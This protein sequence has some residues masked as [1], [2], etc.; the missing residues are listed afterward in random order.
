M[1]Q[2][3]AEAEARLAA[4]QH[5]LQAPETV[6]DAR[7]MEAAWA[8]VQQAQGEVDRLYARWAELEEKIEAFG[9]ARD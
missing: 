8:E 5:A 4:A 3:I 6:S 1:E 2:R 7:R 9:D